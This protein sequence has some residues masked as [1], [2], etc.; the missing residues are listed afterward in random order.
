M[1]IDVLDEADTSSWGMGLGEVGRYEVTLMGI[2]SRLTRRDGRRLSSSTA[3]LRL[4]P[5]LPLQHLRREL[6]KG[7]VEFV[8]RIADSNA[9]KERSCGGGGLYE[10]KLM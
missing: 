5:L 2:I 10:K 7:I 9:F 8:Q 6:K 1:A 4:V 3:A